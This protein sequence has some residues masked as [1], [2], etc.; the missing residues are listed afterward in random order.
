MDGKTGKIDGVPYA[1]GM[2]RLER[3]LGRGVPFSLHLPATGPLF[4]VGMPIVRSWLTSWMFRWSQNGFRVLPLSIISPWG[5][6]PGAML[7][8]S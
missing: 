3:V 5:K 2:K 8:K 4:T 7:D 6:T 1:D